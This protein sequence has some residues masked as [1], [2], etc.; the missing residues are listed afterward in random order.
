MVSHHRLILWPIEAATAIAS[1]GLPLIHRDPFDRL[2]VALA[3]ERRF[4]LVTAD[5]A[6][7]KYPNLKTIW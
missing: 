2:L 1:T 3:Q 6:I 4:T 7:P 5:N